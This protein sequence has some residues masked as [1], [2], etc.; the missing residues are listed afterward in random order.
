M[1]ARRRCYCGTF[2]ENETDAGVTLDAMRDRFKACLT[3]RG[4][5]WSPLLYWI[6]GKERGEEKKRLHLQIFI[7]VRPGCKGWDKVS[8]WLKIK[9]I[10]W[11]TRYANSTDA[12]ARDYCKKKDNVP[13]TLDGDWVDG[14]EF[15][16][17]AGPGQ[18]HRTDWDS[19]RDA[20]VAGA[21]EKTLAL[22]DMQ[23]M[24]CYGHGISR[25]IGWLG[26]VRETTPEDMQVVVFYG[27]PGCGKSKV[28]ACIADWCGGFVR[29]AQ[30]KAWWDGY[31]GQSMVVMD[32]FLGE[33]SD[34]PASAFLGLCGGG[35]CQVAPKHGSRQFL[36]D[37]IIV[38]TNYH[39]TRWYLKF[40]EREAIM[41][42]L[43]VVSFAAKRPEPRRAK[44]IGPEPHK[45]AWRMMEIETWE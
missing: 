6:A 24:S 18:G 14:G 27:Q 19:L 36:A 32:E 38:T 16:E 9:T 45:Q 33:E 28:A 22:S 17:T 5:L 1:K 41:R 7:Q 31:C 29:K 42:R 11:R 10:D 43:T 39:P 35:A 40:Q 3:K 37:L 25:I 4:R 44:Y 12:Q 23:K 30:D 13:G 8:E 34:Y 26:P 2:Y 21:D 20:I 15:E